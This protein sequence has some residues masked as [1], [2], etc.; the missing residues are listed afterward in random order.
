LGPVSKCSLEG[1]QLKTLSGGKEERRREKEGKECY[2]SVAFAL[3]VFCTVY[4]IRYLRQR[5]KPNYHSTKVGIDFGIGFA[6]LVLV[7]SLYT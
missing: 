1:S 6:K 7:A 4:P 2:F 5:L 3:K